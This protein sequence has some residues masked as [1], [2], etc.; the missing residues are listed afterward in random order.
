MDT[1]GAPS[2]DSGSST[3][4]QVIPIRPGLAEPARR[5]LRGRAARGRRT[6]PIR[7]AG[8]GRWLR[9]PGSG[10]ARRW[11]IALLCAA[12]LGLMWWDSQTEGYSG[13]PIN[14]FGQVLGDLIMMGIALPL[15]LTRR[16]REEPTECG[17]PAGE[18]V[19]QIARATRRVQLL[20]VGA[21][22]FPEVAGGTVGVSARGCTC[23]DGEGA[24]AD[25]VAGAEN[26]SAHDGC[27]ERVHRA[28]PERALHIATDGEYA[29]RA[30][31]AILNALR[32]ALARDVPVEI[33][34]PRSE[35]AG[36]AGRTIDQ[37]LASL[38]RAVPTG[39]LDVHYYGDAPA[40]AM[41][42]C[43]DQVWVSFPCADNVSSAA[44]SDDA[45]VYLRFGV[46][47]RNARALILQFARL[48]AA[49]STRRQDVGGA[50][51]A[52]QSPGHARSCADDE[53]AKSQFVFPRQSTGHRTPPAGRSAAAVPPASSASPSQP[54]RQSLGTSKTRESTVRSV[55]FLIVTSPPD[56]PTQSTRPGHRRRRR[57]S[58]PNPDQ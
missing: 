35:L 33:L 56:E 7:S 47:S 40:M 44:V 54:G 15:V 19:N 36:Q 13:L 21:T 52:E 27:R 37:D 49:D 9:S 5:S 14:T 39:K 38:R 30:R 31:S 2:H 58:G 43:D 8:P 50:E 48:A 16:P 11:T 55:S 24:D 57:G 45:G 17:F 46:H 1:T 4:A 22:L 28:G 42:R 51:G 53:A 10:R 6:G 26:F 25:L 32:A 3:F 20:E 34:L 12:V 41:A 23:A 29:L 18:L